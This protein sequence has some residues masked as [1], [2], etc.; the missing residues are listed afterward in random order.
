MG[1]SLARDHET[2]VDEIP[3]E[4]LNQYGRL[5]GMASS[6]QEIADVD[7]LVPGILVYPRF[8]G[9]GNPETC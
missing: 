4:V 8:L 9:S 7:N 2:Q 5:S 6:K 1:N 3:I